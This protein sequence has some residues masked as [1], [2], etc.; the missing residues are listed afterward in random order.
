MRFSA[1][2]PEKSQ[3]RLFNIPK[4]VSGNDVGS[5]KHALDR[6]IKKSKIN[7]LPSI[8]LIDGGKLQLNAALNA[9]SSAR[10]SPLILSIVKGSKRIRSTE[11]ILSKDGVVEIPKESSGFLYFKRFET[12]HIDLPSQQMKEKK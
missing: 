6:R 8:I 11:T 3:Y 12:S 5:I 4:E 7:P 10:E 2:G 1:K 9:F